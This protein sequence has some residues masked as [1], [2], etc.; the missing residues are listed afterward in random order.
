ML[1]AT[2]KTNPLMK[3]LIKMNDYLFEPSNT[4]INPENLVKIDLIDSEIAWL[5]AAPQKY[6]VARKIGKLYA[7][8]LSI[9]NRFSKL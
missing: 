7:L 1:K 3:M 6:W 2:F 9:T 5:E 8:T 4:S